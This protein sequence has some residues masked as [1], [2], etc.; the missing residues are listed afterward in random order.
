M[1]KS[2]L[3][4]NDVEHRLS[5][6]TRKPMRNPAIELAR[7]AACRRWGLVQVEFERE[8]E[9]IVFRGLL[10]GELV[11][12]RLTPVARR[13][14]QHIESELAILRLLDDS[15][16]RV[17][18]PVPAMNGDDVMTRNGYHAV[19]FTTCPGKDPLNDAP[20]DWMAFVHATGQTMATVHE[21]LARV[22]L[23][24]PE[25]REDRWAGVGEV[26]PHDDDEVRDCLPALEAGWAGRESL[27]QGMIHGD[28]T[29][30]NMRYRAGQPPALGLFDFDGACVH[31]YAYEAACFLNVFQRGRIGCD[32]EAARDA[33]LSGYAEVSPTVAQELA[34]HLPFFLCMKALRSYVVFGERVGFASDEARSRRD[35]LVQQCPPR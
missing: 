16:V 27:A 18:L 33:L 10:F 29:L 26:L 11:Y 4:M 3:E 6:G 7:A 30:A 31:W 13:S 32:F 23:V 9:N 22:S 1:V 8:F 5:Q 19:V 25:W 2:L 12:L 35:F 14:A 21:A 34:D 15:G 17:A 28:F 20:D 24:R